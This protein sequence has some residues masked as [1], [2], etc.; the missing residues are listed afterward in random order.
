MTSLIA[1]DPL[2]VVDLIWST[3]SLR[4]S[5]DEWSNDTEHWF[6]DL[7]GWFGGVGIE[8]DQPQRALGHGA[9]PEDGRRTARTLTLSGELY[10]PEQNL[11]EVASR[12]V[13]GIL[14]DGSY[15]TL[16]VT[17]DGVALEA[18]VRLDG[19]IKWGTEGSEWMTI[20]VPLTAPRPWLYGV[21]KS[22][23]LSSASF[24]KGLQWDDGLFSNGGIR[25]GGSQ[26]QPT[27]TND[28][29]ADAW[30]VVK[31]TGDFSRGFRLQSGSSV[32]EFPEPV[33]PRSPVTVDMGRG[34]IRTNGADMGHLASSR[35][36]I[37]IPPRSTI[38]P[39]LTGLDQYSEGYAEVSWTDTY[40]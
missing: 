12:Y 35:G 22:V 36:W 8:G 6:T 37:K 16:R 13:S 25:W 31:V 29:N 17:T 33:Y 11:R 9:F 4:L 18:S 10:F 26:P 34:R 19:A 39:R 5:N 28:G 24:G 23:Q 27:V 2:R 14:A 38:S 21:K 3:G 1:G 30:P 20:E 15:G 40:I 32:V 7:E